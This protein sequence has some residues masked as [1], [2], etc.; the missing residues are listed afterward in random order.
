MAPK[1]TD[2]DRL[3]RRLTRYGIGLGAVAA[4][5]VSL[6]QKAGA[7]IVY[8]GFAGVTVTSNYNVLNLRF[9]GQTDLVAA[10]SGTFAVGF[11]FEL[12]C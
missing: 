5:G 1:Q 3:A 12:Y 4:A 6:P 9:E 11:N 2:L 10:T 8:R 7:E